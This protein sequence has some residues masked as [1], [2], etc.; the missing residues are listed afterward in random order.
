MG[1][2]LG[3][4]Q[5]VKPSEYP[6]SLGYNYEPLLLLRLPL[7]LLLLKKRKKRLTEYFTI[8]IK[9]N[10]YSNSPFLATASFSSFFFL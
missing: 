5:S 10:G 9:E 6:L 2:L 4:L 3:P 1:N 7:M 8:Y